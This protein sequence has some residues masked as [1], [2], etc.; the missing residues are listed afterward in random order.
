MSYENSYGNEAAR[1]VDKMCGLSHK[2]V[3]TQVWQATLKV[4]DNFPINCRSSIDW[5]GQLVS[6]NFPVKRAAVDSKQARG[7]GL[8]PIGFS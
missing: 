1:R 7:F 4:S 3:A 8:V 6:F 5:F 2:C